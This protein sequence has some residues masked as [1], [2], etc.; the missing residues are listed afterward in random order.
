M[1]QEIVDVLRGISSA[2]ASMYDG[3]LDEEGNPVEIGLKREEGNPALDS[4]VID[5]CKVR[6]N[7]KTL[8]VSYHSECKLKDVYSNSFMNDLEQTMADIV[9]FLKK[10]YRK[11]TGKTL[12]LKEKGECNAKVESTS[13]VRVFV[14]ASKDYEISSLGKVDDPNAGSKDSLEAS[15]KK[16]LDQDAG[17]KRPKNDKRKAEKSS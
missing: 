11:I 14:T 7:G 10:R 13:R 16:F 1:S 17:N 6:V 2:A 9:K 4:R 12:S 3:A 5:G 15:F 8:I